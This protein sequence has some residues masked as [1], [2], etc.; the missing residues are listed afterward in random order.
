MIGFVLGTSEGKEILSLMNEFTEDIVVS[1]ATKYGGDLLKNFKTRYIN[2]EPLD[3]E[4]FVKLIKRFN[5]KT[6][7]DVSHPYAKEVSSIVMEACKEENIQYIRYERRSFL[8]DMNIDD[9][10]IKIKSYSELKD[11]LKNING[12][13]LNTTGSNNVKGI[14]DLNLKKRI[15]HRILPSPIIL[16]NLINSGVDIGD[17]IAVKGPCGY[18]FNDGIIKDYKIKALITKDSGIKGGTKE[19]IEAAFNNNVQVIVIER[20]EINYGKTFDDIICL[21]NYLKAYMK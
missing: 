8:K 6:F 15:I 5:I 20:P 9:K 14:I 19:K 13:I 11:V 16:K 4:G 17:I 1:T 3:K 18:Y 12:V 7:V 10:V 21:A 2:S